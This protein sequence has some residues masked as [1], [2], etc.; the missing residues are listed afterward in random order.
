MTE[1]RR[2]L[3]RPRPDATATDGGMYFASEKENLLF[4]PSG[5]V[6]LDRVLGGGWALGRIVNVVGD[7]STGKTLLAMEALAN[8]L[9]KWPEGEV[10]YKECEYAFDVG[11]AEQGLGIPMSKVNLDQGG[12]ATVEDLMRDVDGLIKRKT[13]KGEQSGTN[14]PH[15]TL[16]IVDSL[17][18]ISDEA[19]MEREVGKGNYGASKAKMLSEFFRTRNAPLARAN[20]CLFIVSQVRENLNAGMFGQKFLRSGGKA[21]DFFASQVIWLYNRGMIK[22]GVKEKIE[23]VIGVEIL[24]KN[25]KNKVGLPYRDCEFDI[26]FGYGVEDEKASREWLTKRLGKPKLAELAG[27]ELA[28]AVTREWFAVETTYLPTERKYGPA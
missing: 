7:K 6:L 23:R 25:T 3:I 14:A 4:I 11:Y 10:H 16:Y 27:A 19:E 20:V 28:A 13:K 2:R 22:K 21:L 12:I 17:D 5:C 1:V 24:A 9:R 15:P 8:F 18:S 26:R